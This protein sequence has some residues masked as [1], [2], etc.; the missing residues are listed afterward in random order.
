MYRLAMITDIHGNAHALKAALNDIRNKSID[1]IYCLGDMIGIGPFPNDVLEALLEINNLSMI[2]GNHD[3][4]VLALLKGEPYPKSRESVI[5]HHRWIAERINKSN[6]SK[7][8][9][10]PRF[11]DLTIYGQKLHLIHYPMNQQVKFAHISKDPFDQSGMPSQKNFSCI[12]G[13]DEYSLICFGHDHS[14]HHFICNKKT[15]YNPG[16]LGCSNQPY[17][18]YGIVEIDS[19]SFRIEQRYVPYDFASYVKEIKQSTMP[20][21][22]II[23][24]IY[25]G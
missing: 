9:E 6:I 12:N 15:F 21:K 14:K 3:E 13:L 16:S 7:L 23:L 8:E 17:A 18:R 1:H 25:E 10:L 4:A 20:R 2:T 19:N 22:E 24:G 11:I 5:P